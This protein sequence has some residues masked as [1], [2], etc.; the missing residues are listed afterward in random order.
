MLTY[1]RESGWDVHRQLRT[2]YKTRAVRLLL[3]GARLHI[4][5]LHQISEQHRA[6]CYDRKIMV[7][8][9]LLNKMRQKGRTA[10][11]RPLSDAE[12]PSPVGGL[13]SGASVDF[14]S[15]I[16]PSY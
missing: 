4:P 8:T 3:Y 7:I 15:S 14:D 1:L 11:N 9:S 10:R 12:Q 13:A 16:A 2:A 5:A 6:A